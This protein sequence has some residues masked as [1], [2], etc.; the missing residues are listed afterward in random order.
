[1][2]SASNSDVWRGNEKLQSCAEIS[3][4]NDQIIVDLISLS[5][6]PDDAI[7]DYLQYIAA[8]INLLTNLCRGRKEEYI[9][10]VRAADQITSRDIGL[11]ERFCLAILEE[12]EMK[13]NPRIKG[14]IGEFYSS[15]LLDKFP[16][17]RLS[18]LDINCFEYEEIA[19]LKLQKSPIFWI[20]QDLGNLSLEQDRVDK[21]NAALRT[22]RE[23]A[24]KKFQ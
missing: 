10:Q 18:N 7:E 6:N 14:A 15:V 5:Q 17:R 16:L 8:Y 1:M 4:S 13:V 12:N 20:N 23:S 24:F 11:D 21:V 2:S 19:K 22:M 3:K 9:S